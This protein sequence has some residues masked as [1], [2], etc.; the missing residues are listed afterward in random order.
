[1]TPRNKA[2]GHTVSSATSD[3]DCAKTIKLISQFGTYVDG[4]D[5][6]A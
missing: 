5:V 1:V 6:C 3:G 2:A 4:L